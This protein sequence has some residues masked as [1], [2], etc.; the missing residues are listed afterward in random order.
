MPDRSAWLKKTKTVVVE[1][2]G[3]QVSVTFA[4]AKITPRWE[5]EFNEALKSEWKSRAMVE[6]LATVIVDWDITSDGK[7]FPP[8][9]ANL[10]QLPMELLTA[11]FVAIME[12]Q[13]PNATRSGA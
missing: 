2:E 1:F 5:Q 7:P 4:P 12:A 10:A 8:T 11:I 9:E 6:T 13:R 3:E